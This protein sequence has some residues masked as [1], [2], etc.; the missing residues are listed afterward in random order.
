MIVPAGLPGDSNLA[1]SKAKKI[2]EEGKS[3]EDLFEK[4]EWLDHLW[5]FDVGQ[6]L[7]E[8]L[9]FQADSEIECS[10]ELGDYQP[11]RDFTIL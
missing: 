7:Q 9:M 5:L 4:F 10:T 2:E 6:E 1:Q 11:K 8:L 3:E